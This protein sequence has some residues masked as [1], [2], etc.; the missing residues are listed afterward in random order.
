MNQSP[1]PPHVHPLLIAG[2]FGEDTSRRGKEYALAH[3]VQDSDWG[4]SEG[5]VVGIVHGSANH[6]YEVVVRLEVLDRDRRITHYRP[7]SSHC[8]CPVGTNCKHGAALDRKSVV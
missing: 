4:P 7:T 8:T 1:V 3:R 6:P 5:T 2:L